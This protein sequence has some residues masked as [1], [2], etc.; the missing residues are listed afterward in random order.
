MTLSVVLLLLLFIRFERRQKQ[1][2]KCDDRTAVIDDDDGGG[3]HDAIVSYANRRSFTYFLL[4]LKRIIQQSYA[5][6]S[7]N[8]FQSFD[9]T[10][11]FFTNKTF[12]S[13]RPVELF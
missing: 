1:K 7:V 5:M 6:R 9:K 12:Y 3:D 10:N 13:V 4:Y 11:H 8:V 2:S